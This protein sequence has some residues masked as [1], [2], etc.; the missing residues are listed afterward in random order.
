MDSLSL[1]DLRQ[2]GI[3]FIILLASLTI[4]EWA[5]AWTADKLGDPTPASEGRVT[6]NPA[7]HLDWLGSLIIPA[8][9]IF[10]LSG[11]SLIGWGKPVMVNPSYFRRRVRDHLLTVLAGPASNLVLALVAAIAY[12]LFPAA[13]EIFLNL[14]FVNVSLAV[15][16]LLPLPPLDGGWLLKYATGMRDETFIRVGF[17]MGFILL[18]LINVPQFRQLL[19]FLIG[20]ALI[21][22]RAI[23]GF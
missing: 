1:M 9:N 15:F 23:A 18:I 2:G 21:P 19:G 3:L 17:M 4:H 12:R 5:H 16:N 6:L 20:S 13:G 11:F 8:L 22:F 10:L 7:S 14:L